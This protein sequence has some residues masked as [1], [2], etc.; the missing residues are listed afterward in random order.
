MSNS[1]VAAIPSVVDVRD[2]GGGKL[3]HLEFLRRGRWFGGLPSDLQQRV[4][5]GASVRAFAK[6]SHIV[7][8]GE[9][10]RGLFALLEGRV[11]VLRFLGEAGSALIHVGEPGF[12]FGEHAL[13]A[14]KKA[15]ASVVASTASRALVLPADEFRRLV[16]EEPDYYPLVAALLFMRYET[17][18]RYASEA[19]ALP[20]EEWLL[21]RLR[22]LAAIRR[23][24][25]SITGPIDVNVSQ[26]E[27][28]TMV[29]VSRQTLCTL[30]RRLEERGEVQ[31]AYKKIRVL[32]PDRPHVA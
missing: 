3:L 11:H 14:G 2:P 20:A 32:P 10:V 21:R 22:D 7:R 23:S 28:A 15:I 9:P 18:F 17:V 1:T 4:V 31:V 25:A 13:L 26:A 27:L 12:W 29:G 8:E 19:R 6:G 24:D 5:E 30:L 16:H